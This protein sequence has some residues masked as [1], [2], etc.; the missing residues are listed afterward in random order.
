MLFPA[1]AEAAQA[2]RAAL[3]V[4]ENKVPPPA[5]DDISLAVSEAVT[6]AIQHAHQ[7]AVA[8]RVTT[9][10]DCVTVVV[11]DSGEGFKPTLPPEPGT[12]QEYGW[13]LYLVNSVSD[14]WG[15]T[16]GHGTRVWFEISLDRYEEAPSSGSAPSR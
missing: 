8:V 11:E 1:V 7:D 9:A 15:V 6:N 10:D 16:V 4:L 5:M 3:A 14:R 2:S 13:G 12:L